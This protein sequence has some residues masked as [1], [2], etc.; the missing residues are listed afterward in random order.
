MTKEIIDMMYK[1]DY[2]HKMASKQK[3]IA[4]WEEYKKHR[5][6]V[7]H[8]I[9][10]QQRVYYNNEITGNKNNRNGMWKSLR[11]LLKSSKSSHL[12]AELTVKVLNDFFSNIC[13]RM[14]EKYK[15]ASYEWSLPQSAYSFNY[16]ETW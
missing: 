4:L 14:A 16:S 1:I 9:N 15:D 8:E 7:V 12:P 6:M 5:N 3:D 10:K 13:E 11:H 2:L